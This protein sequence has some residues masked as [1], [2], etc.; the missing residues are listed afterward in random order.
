MTNLQDLL[1]LLVGEISLPTLDENGLLTP[2]KRLTLL[3]YTP[4]PFIKREYM[5]DAELLQHAGTDLILD[6]EFYPNYGM[7]GFKHIKTG[8]YLVLENDYNPRKLS[9][10]MFSYRTIGFNS[11]YFDLPLVWASYHNRDPAFLKSVTNA[12]IQRGMYGQDAAKEF[13]FTIYRLPRFQ[14]IDLI[15]VCPLG[16]S[17]KLY[18]ARLHSKRL[19]DLPFP[20]D[21]NLEPWQID[22]VRGYN[23]NDLDVTELVYNF[24]KMQERLELR[25]SI[26]M[27]Y[28]L[29]LMSKSDAQM[30]EAVISK[31]VGKLNK[32][33]VKRPEIEPGTTYKY[34]PPPYLSYRTEAMQK[35]F[36]AIKRADFTIAD[37]GKMISPPCLSETVAI[38]KGVYT[39]GIGGLHSNEKC[40][41]YEAKNGK[42]L[43]DTDVVS[44]Y[45]NAIVNLKLIPVAMGPN[46]L[47]VYKGFKDQRVEAKR[48]KQFTKDKGLKIFLNGV[49][50]K[51]SDKYSTMYSPH[52]TIQMNLTGQ[53]S[54]L[55]LAEMF[56]LNGIEVISANTDGIVA[57]YD[58]ADEAKLEYWTDYWRKLTGFDTETVEYTKYYARDVNNYFA[59][60][61]KDVKVKGVWSEVGSQSGTQLDNNPIMLICSDAIKAFLSVGT[62]IEET[63]NACQ[64]ITRFIIVRQVKGGA[65]FRGEYLGKVVRWYY[66][67]SSTDC[68]QTVMHGSRVATSENCMPLMDIGETLPTDLDR[69]RYIE[70]TKQALYDIG[71]FKRPEK[72]VFF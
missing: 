16:K 66:S 44:Y 20:P 15:E 51:L 33:Y 6:G 2:D 58:E 22:E 32:Q 18:G 45:P 23:A 26:S 47:T 38:N 55:M 61:E 9:W 8:K 42:K 69:N 35:M 62:P 53:L 5:T 50:G 40:V 56:E 1:K 59:V 60:K 21:D 72:V 25:R 63:I 27:D 17:L 48:T 64:N 70:L 12:I 65:A 52:L 24:D 30:A 49:S 7:F 37:S 29:D 71:Y 31:E 54:I 13:G 19:Q 14:H 46:F 67:K 41:G 43:K 39:L 28:D 4:R 57:Y 10:I 3:P 68:I 36:A 11:I 34:T